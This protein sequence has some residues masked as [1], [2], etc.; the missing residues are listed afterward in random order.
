V[1]SRSDGL[2]I[3]FA[4]LACLGGCEVN[5]IVGCLVVGRLL[6]NKLDS[7]YGVQAYYW[8]TASLRNRAPIL[9]VLSF[10]YHVGR[11]VTKPCVCLPLYVTN[12]KFILSE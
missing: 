6:M 10:G 4:Y 12:S 7:L 8:G 9:Q 5:S 3:C 2:N 11:A 1:R